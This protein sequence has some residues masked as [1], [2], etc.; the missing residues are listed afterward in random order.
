MARDSVSYRKNNRT[1]KEMQKPLAKWGFGVLC[2]FFL[3]QVVFHGWIAEELSGYFDA[4]KT[5][6]FLEMMAFNTGLLLLAMLAWWTTTKAVKSRN[7]DTETKRFSLALAFLLLLTVFVFAFSNLSLK[8]EYL[9][10][11][12]EVKW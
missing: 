4:A 6:F 5:V 7:A 9:E 10:R 8:F 12:R 2:V 1:E 11:T 3:V